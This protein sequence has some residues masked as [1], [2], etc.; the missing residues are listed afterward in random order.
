MD[1]Y[2][3]SKK[4]GILAMICIPVFI[5][6]L[7]ITN[8]LGIDMR[9]FIKYAASAYRIL[10]IVQLIIMM[11]WGI[12]EYGSAAQIEDATIYLRGILGGFTAVLFSTALEIFVK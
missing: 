8:A 12:L 2:K 7:M 9:V 11:Y 10:G 1:E 4:T 3:L 5:I 6:I